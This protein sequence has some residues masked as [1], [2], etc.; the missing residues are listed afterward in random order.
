MS[1]GHSV[2]LTL[3]GLCPMLPELKLLKSEYTESGIKE[4]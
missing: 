2:L 1:R 3:K 4:I